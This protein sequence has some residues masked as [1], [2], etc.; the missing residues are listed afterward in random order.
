MKFIDSSITSFD[1]TKSILYTNDTIKLDSF[2]ETPLYV[3][4]SD[5]YSTETN[6]VY[7]EYF[8]ITQFKK[9]KVIGSGGFGNVYEIQNKD[10]NM[11]QK[12]FLVYM[13]DIT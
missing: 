12:Y 6:H 13:I 7:L 5:I 4:I 9:T 11:Q 1:S 3:S 10:G 8:S 2:I